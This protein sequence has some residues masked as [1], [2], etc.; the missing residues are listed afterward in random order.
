MISLVVRAE[1]KGCKMRPVN[2][3]GRALKAG[4]RGSDLIVGQMEN[5]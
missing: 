3:S 4:V 2:W 5:H 1:E